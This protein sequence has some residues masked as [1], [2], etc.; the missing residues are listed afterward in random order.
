MRFR[1][2]IWDFDG[3]LFDTYPALN[4]IIRQALDDFGVTETEER[5]AALLS[6]TLSNTVETLVTENNLDPAAFEARIDHHFAQIT[7]ADRPPFPGA[8][9]VC[10]R[11]QAAGGRSYIYTHRDRESLMRFL[12]WQ[13]V[14]ELFAGIVTRDDGYPRKPDPTGFLALIATYDLPKAAVL[15][16]GDR[17]LDIQAAHGAGVAGCLFSAQPGDGVTPEYVIADFAELEQ[18]LGI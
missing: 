15:A 12:D 9:R 3:T 17:D 14:A 18:I 7:L 2:L 8:I 1:Y 4:R 10:E 5:V 16:V 6:D 13:N 11:F